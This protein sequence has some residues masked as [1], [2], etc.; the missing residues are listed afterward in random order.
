MTTRYL[1]PMAGAVAMTFVLFF[2]MQFLV[3]SETVEGFI[4][5]PYVWDL[6]RFD[7]TITPTKPP[8]ELPVKPEV[9]PEPTADIRPIDDQASKPVGKL[10]VV[11]SKEGTNPDGGGSGIKG[12]V[13]GSM[14]QD[15][16]PLVIVEPIYPIRKR[17]AGTEGYVVLEFTVDEL[18]NVQNPR[19]LYAEPAGA[20]ETVAIR[21]IENS[22]FRPVM[23]DGSPVAVTGVRYK[24]V[25]KLN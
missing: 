16:V 3:S 19:A 4:H 1:P 5:K 17:E 10:D 22:R 11:F 13:L 8:D 15:M 12:P 20:F 23:I 6:P 24:Y 9:E 18:G 2:V 14:N 25:F 7:T 21:A